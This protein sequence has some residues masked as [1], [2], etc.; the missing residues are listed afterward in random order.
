MKFSPRRRVAAVV[1]AMGLGLGLGACSS[2]PPLAT[3]A[4]VDLPRFMGP[5]FVIATIPTFLETDA[6][7]AV[8]TYELS[9]DGSIATTF[10]FRQSGF[11]GPLKTYHP[12]GFVRDATTNATWGM[13]FVWPFKAEF[14]ITHLDAHYTQTVIGRTARDHVWIMA[15][16]PTPAD[17]DYTGLVEELRAQGYPVE[18]LRRVPQ[19]WPEVVAVPAASVASLQSGSPAVRVVDV[20][21]P[22]EFA[23]G[24]VPGAVN[25]PLERVQADPAA[26]GLTVGES[27]VVYCVTGLRA[28][29]A[30]A[31]LQAR[32]FKDVRQLEG[33]FAAWQ[34]EGRPVERLPN[35]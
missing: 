5:W 28:G 4:R 21:S 15:R 2:G 10:T 26:A 32:G 31:A 33:H 13:Q 22:E 8:E 6:W 30:A 9:P 29:R 20:R 24:H 14:L 27:L 35:P 17:A 1:L 25:V 12:R 19:R 7:N 34:A 3:V 18:R 16:T 23:Q 11:D